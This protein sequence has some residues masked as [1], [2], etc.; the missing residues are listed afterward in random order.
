MMMI[1]IDLAAREIRGQD[2]VSLIFLAGAYIKE[3][4]LVT[5]VLSRR[6]LGRL[7]ICYRQKWNSRL[8]LNFFYLLKNEW[9]KVRRLKETENQPRL[10]NFNLNVIL[11]CNIYFVVNS[12]ILN[13]LRWH[14]DRGWL[15]FISRCLSK[16]SVRKFFCFSTLYCKQSFSFLRSSEHVCELTFGYVN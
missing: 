6:C 15:Q 16:V 4:A 7:C 1:M 12:S 14:N 11:T 13:S 8:I 3:L 5:V 10:K 9:N 2:Q